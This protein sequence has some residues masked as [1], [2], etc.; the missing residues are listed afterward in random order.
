M[1]AEKILEKCGLTAVQVRAANGRHVRTARTEIAL[2]V[3]DET[4]RWESRRSVASAMWCPTRVTARAWAF[5][6]YG[7]TGPVEIGCLPA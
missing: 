4:E 7:E 1:S 3:F 6:L 2:V 5:S